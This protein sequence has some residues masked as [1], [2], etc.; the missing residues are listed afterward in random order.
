MYTIEFQKR[1]LPHAHIL[2]WLDGDN[3]L[4]TGKDIDK[5][6]SAEIPHP[7]LYPKLH[8]AVATY[9]IHGPCGVANLKSPCMEG[10]KCTKFYPKKF[11]TSTSIDSDGYPCYKRHNSEVSVHKFGINLDNRSVVP[12]NPFLL[13][14]YQGHINTEYCNKSNAIKYLFKYVNKGPDRSNLEIRNGSHISHEAAPI[15][16]IQ[17]YYDCRYLSP[18]EAVWRIFAFDIHQKWPSVMRLTLHLP[19]E[20]S[21]LF[22]DEDSID[23]VVSR[24]EVLGTMFL[25]WFRANRIYAEGRDLTYAEFPTKFVYFPKERRWQPRKQGFSIG[26]LSYVPVG[27]GE[28]YYMRILLTVQKGCVGYKSLRKV[29][30]K[31]HNNFQDACDAL[32][33]LA[34]DKEY[35]DA[36]IEASKTSSGNQIRKLFVRLLMMNT[37]TKAN[38]VWDST[39]KLLSD[40]IVYHKRKTLNISGNNLYF[41]HISIDG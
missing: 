29:N 36:I 20:Q 11:E 15:D 39:W 7:D 3:R 9:M 18:C 1:G 34:D 38:F 16:E 28:L 27:A 6:I 26:R 4:M 31:V 10:R 30:G 13:M 37:M 25:A 40:G 21:L 8:S 2:L 5:V 14:R 32:G 41:V 22:D 24:N 23:D 17:R 33:L 12:Y 35:I 19:N